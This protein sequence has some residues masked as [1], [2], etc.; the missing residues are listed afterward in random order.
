MTAAPSRRTRP[1]V[2]P[3]RREGA[4]RSSA[5]R[6]SQ[7]ALA[8]AVQLDPTGLAERPAPKHLR[9]APT[10]SKRVLRQRR[11]ARWL[12][13][14]VAAISAASMFLLVTFHVFAVGASFQLDKLEHRRADA[15]RHNELLR[16]LVATR[17]S[18]TTIFNAAML[19]GMQRKIPAL[20]NVSGT[21]ATVPPPAAAPVT[22]P[23]FE[24]GANAAA[25]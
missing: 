15:Q 16:N 22:M 13:V 12:V 4:A 20:V 8:Q 23:K 14:G 24:Y 9:V 1:P 3:A 18:A 19:L 6:G 7:N 5:G 17:S 21:G 11:R 2:H 25:P 10:V